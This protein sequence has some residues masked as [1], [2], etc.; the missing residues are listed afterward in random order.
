MP[1]NLDGLLSIGRNYK[2]SS[3]SESEE[4]EEAE[5]GAAVGSDDFVNIETLPEVFQG[6]DSS[7][8]ASPMDTREIANGCPQI[9]ASTSVCVQTDLAGLD[10]FFCEK[11]VKPLMIFE[12]GYSYRAGPAAVA[13]VNAAIIMMVNASTQSAE[14]GVNV[15]H[16]ATQL[17]EM[18]YNPYTNKNIVKSE[19]KPTDVKQEK[20]YSVTDSDIKPPPVMAA[21]TQT[22]MAGYA[23]LHK[24]TQHPDKE[25][26]DP[27]HPPAP[28]PPIFW[29][30][31]Q[32]LS[33]QLAA[34]AAQQQQLQYLQQ[35]QQLQYTLLDSTTGLP[36]YPNMAAS[37]T[38][39]PA[40]TQTQPPAL[41]SQQSAWPPYMQYPSYDHL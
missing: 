30:D 29:S 1:D 7:S 24:A 8:A 9:V 13:D 6:G 2:L 12:E 15:Y 36:L 5:D 26:P 31:Q 25:Y 16:K 19:L 40:F 28:A 10:A 18:S 34:A 20:V 17:P 22:T 23:V 41:P 21:S 4:Q 33:A 11:S 3:I 39:P 32:L 27:G 37:Q 38:Q 35:Q 14:I